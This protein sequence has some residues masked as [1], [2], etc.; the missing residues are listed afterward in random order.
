MS[1]NLITAREMSDLHEKLKKKVPGKDLSDREVLILAKLR[2]EDNLGK[3]IIPVSKL[4][5]N[6]GEELWDFISSL[7][8]AVHTNR[9]L[10]GDGSM[11]IWIQGIFDDF[12]VVMDMNTGKLFKSTFK[13]NAEGEFDF[14]EPV[15][16]I[17][18]FVEANRSEEGKVELK[19]GDGDMTEETV[20][21]VAKSANRIEF[22]NLNKGG[23]SRWGGIL[24]SVTGG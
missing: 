19:V 16:V 23:K 15:E 6:E 20:Q 7:S 17:S 12:V 14:S 8:T 22:V 10:L 1:E 4:A 2:R 24:G 5:L 13:R 21:R 9:V 18:T 3:N 11:D